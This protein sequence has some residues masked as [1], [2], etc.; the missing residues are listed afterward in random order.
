MPA[1]EVLAGRHPPP[2]VRLHMS[3]PKA[4]AQLMTAL[5]GVDP[6]AACV[7]VAIAAL[8]GQGVPATLLAGSELPIW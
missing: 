8:A 7:R 1:A 3:D 4:V 5:P 2:H 6:R